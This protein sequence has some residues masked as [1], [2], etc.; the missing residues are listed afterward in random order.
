[1]DI[2]RKNTKDGLPR[3]RASK[4]GH[5]QVVD[6]LNAAHVKSAVESA[7]ES[8]ID[9]VD[10]ALTQ[11]TRHLHA[12]FVERLLVPAKKELDFRGYRGY[13][14]YL[15]CSAALNGQEMIVKLFLAAKTNYN[16]HDTVGRSAF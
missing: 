1:V 10:C 2:Y 12:R 6:L 13:R 14:E 15:L 9:Y 5:A 4:M 3:S 7:V 16:A 8:A 11:A